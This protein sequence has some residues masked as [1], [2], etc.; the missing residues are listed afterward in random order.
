M[1]DDSGQPTTLTGQPLVS[2]DWNSFWKNLFY[3]PTPAASIDE[4][5]IPAPKTEATQPSQRYPFRPITPP[6]VDNKN[7]P[8]YGGSRAFAV[9]PDASYPDDPV[10][11]STMGFVNQD[12]GTSWLVLNQYY[13]GQTS[14]AN[15]TDQSVVVAP[16]NGD[17]AMGDDQTS[18]PSQ[19]YSYASNDDGGGAV[20]HRQPMQSMWTRNKVYGGGR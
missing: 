10:T 5:Q 15:L 16:N 12:V 14:R 13:G 3:K 4:T 17:P 18:A 11:Q 20:D 9:G 6:R 19:D 8:W 1:A 2:F 7:Q